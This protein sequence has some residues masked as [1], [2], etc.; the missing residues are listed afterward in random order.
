MGLFSLKRR[1]GMRCG[2]AATGGNFLQRPPSRTR[3]IGR[4]FTR[5]PARAALPPNGAFRRPASGL[6]KRQSRVA[7]WCFGALL[8]SFPPPRNRFILSV[9][10]VRGKK[11]RAA[12]MRPLPYVDLL[13]HFHADCRSATA[14]S[15][16]RNGHRLHFVRR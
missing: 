7:P 4:V 13:L 2:A 9:S 14:H 11:F 10:S 1:P 12:D 5:R 8:P 15:A 6:L 3:H 16:A